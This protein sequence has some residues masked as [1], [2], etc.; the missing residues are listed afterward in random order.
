[1]GKTVLV[2]GI[3]FIIWA[4]ISCIIFLFG[5]NKKRKIPMLA[6]TVMMGIG[7]LVFVIF[8]IVVFMNPETSEEAAWIFSL[9][10]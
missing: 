4:V 2:V 3:I 5:I 1:M 8:L 10:I 9:L 6:G 7:V